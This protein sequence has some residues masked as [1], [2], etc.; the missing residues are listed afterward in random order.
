MPD[1]PRPSRPIL[2]DIVRI[3]LVAYLDPVLHWVSAQIYAEL[4]KRADD[5]GL[6]DLHAMWD[7]APLESACAAFHH[8]AGPGTRPTHPV[9][10]LVRAL[11][12]GWS[13]RQLEFQIRVHVVIKWFV[14]YP[15]FASGPDHAALERFEQWVSDQ[16]HRL[17]F[18]EVLRQIDQDFPEQR[19]QPQIG[20]TFALRATAAKESLIT[21]LRHTARF[22]LAALEE[23]A[24]ERHLAIRSPC[25]DLL[26]N[27]TPI[28]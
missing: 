4:L 16:Q 12:C 21:L 2:P 13:L 22:R 25:S 24:P 26:M 17:L 20:D 9:S 27:R 18:D 8:T 7:F 15:L 28:G 19:T 6:I 3:V 14:G 10:H 5:H 1:E 11:L 23:A